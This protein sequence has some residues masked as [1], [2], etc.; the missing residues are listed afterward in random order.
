MSIPRSLAFQCAT[1]SPP[2]LDCQAPAIG[3]NAFH[4]VLRP[5]PVLPDNVSECCRSSIYMTS[6]RA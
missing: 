5:R 3:D 6:L 2:A 1:A 4:F